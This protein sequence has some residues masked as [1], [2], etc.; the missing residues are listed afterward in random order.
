MRYEAKGIGINKAENKL[1]QS[2]NN[3]QP[4]VKRRVRLTRAEFGN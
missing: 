1:H 3:K 4:K 2:N